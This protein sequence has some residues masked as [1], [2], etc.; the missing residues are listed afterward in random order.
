MSLSVRAKHAYVAV[1]HGVRSVL[2]ATGVLGAL[3]T[4]AGR[5]RTGLWVRSWFAVHDLD[6]LVALDTPWW[7]FAAADEVEAF[8]ADRVDARVFEWGSGASTVWLSTRASS[9]TSVEHD[10]AWARQ[11]VPVLPGNATLILVEPRPCESPATASSKAGF[12]GLDFTDYVAALDEVEGDFDVIVVD[13]R[14]REACLARALRR[15]RPG[16]LVVVDNVER[17]RY[18]A[19]IGS[20]PSGPD[21][22]SVRW[23]RGRTPA[24]PYPTQTALVSRPVDE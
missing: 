6:D 4:W 12:A 16:G 10:A 1:V 9:V 11:L 8:L 19:A 2:A 18:R 15:L 3:D 7:T 13:G 21:G 14:A 24:L 20:L 17:G 5:S 22:V 23:T